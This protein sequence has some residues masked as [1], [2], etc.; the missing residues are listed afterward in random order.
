M[1]YGKRRILH[2]VDDF[3]LIA[4]GQMLVADLLQI[5]DGRDR[6]RC[7]TRHIKPKIVP[8]AFGHFLSNHFFG[9]STDLPAGSSD[10]A[11]V[12]RLTPMATRSVAN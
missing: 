9:L 8:V 6:F 4:A 3:D 12:W 1:P 2:Q 7:L 11:P 5:G 10:L